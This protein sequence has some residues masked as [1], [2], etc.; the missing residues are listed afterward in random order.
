MP[1]LGK[2]LDEYAVTLIDGQEL[3]TEFIL[4]PNLEEAAWRAFELSKDHNAELK[5]V[6][7]TD[8]W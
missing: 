6:I 7:R 8:E 2:N 1:L 5:D 3:W 4:A